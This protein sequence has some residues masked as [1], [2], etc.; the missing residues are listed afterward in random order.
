MAFR[1]CTQD[2]PCR[3]RLPSTLFELIGEIVNHERDSTEPSAVD[4][5]AIEDEMPLIE[6]EIGLLDVQIRIMAAHGPVDEVTAQRL[7]RSRDAVIAESLRWY[8]RRY[9]ATRRAA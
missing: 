1:P 8:V 6:A 3:N 2:R 9:N 7:R 5:E 4:L